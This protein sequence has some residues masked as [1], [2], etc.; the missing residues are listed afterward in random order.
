MLQVSVIAQELIPRIDEDIHLN[1]VTELAVSLDK[2]YFAL[3]DADGVVTFRDVETGKVLAQ[4]DYDEQIEDIAFSQNEGCLIVVSTYYGDTIDY[5]YVEYSDFIHEDSLALH[6]FEDLEVYG[7]DFSEQDD[8]VLITP[9]EGKPKLVN[10]RTGD[11]LSIPVP[12]DYSSCGFNAKGNCII[13]N[14][15]EHNDDHEVYEYDIASKQ[16]K[17]IRTLENIQTEE[18]L[19]NKLSY[20]KDGQLILVDISIDASVS[21]PEQEYLRDSGLN[22]FDFAFSPDGKYVAVV[23]GNGTRSTGSQ[24]GY[25]VNQIIFGSGFVDLY[26]VKT[27]KKKWGTTNKEKQPNL[28]IKDVDWTSNETFIVGDSEGNVFSMSI[29]KEFYYR[30]FPLPRKVV[31]YADV[32]RDFSSIVYSQKG[33]AT[34]QFDIRDDGRR[35]ALS[36]V[37]STK[38]SFSKNG[39]FATTPPTIN[40]AAPINDYVNGLNKIYNLPFGIYSDVEGMALS[41][42]GNAFAISTSEKY[43]P[44]SAFVKLPSTNVE[45]TSEGE[46]KM[47]EFENYFLKPL[48][49]SEASNYAT[50][51][52]NDDSDLSY[53]SEPSTVVFNFEKGVK[54]TLLKG[55]EGKLSFSKDGSLL[56]IVSEDLVDRVK[57]YDLN[58]EEWYSMPGEQYALKYNHFCQDHPYALS[59]NQ[60]GESTVWHTGTKEIIYKGRLEPTDF[61]PNSPIA[62]TM[63]NL[64]LQLDLFAVNVSFEPDASK[65]YIQLQDFLYV[66]DTKTG[67]LSDYDLHEGLYNFSLS[68]NAK[69]HYSEEID[70]ENE[71][72]WSYIWDH[73]GNMVIYEKPFVECYD[74][75]EG[76]SLTGEIYFHESKP[77]AF[78]HNAHSTFELIDLVEEE[79]I[80][81]LKFFENGEWV[82]FAPNGLFDGS[83]YG[84][85]AIYYTYGTE[86]ILFN[87]IK[88]KYWQPDLL[89]LLINN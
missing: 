49:R 35:A 17:L 21:I 74:P 7:I 31:T 70:S 79:L 82:V 52:E 88:N 75:E 43:E 41:E 58:N 53:Y 89:N 23:G 59:M 2:K 51:L 66:L 22:I 81:T 68:P 44:A 80:A 56:S 16:L 57:I 36:N 30:A 46:I 63:S 78:V 60:Y 72:T 29:A 3:A 83:K 6:T 32:S 62:Q 77:L 25:V 24:T 19:N 38:V 15:T 13:Y 67:Q 48:N 40:T 4:E 11:T 84:R 10:Y 8:Y 14:G 85:N 69:Y 1:D 37:P 26:E 87:Q 39:L 73:E 20:T 9:Q 28:D 76:K 18:D 27:G 86:V 71:R 65:M 34:Y 55:A 42:G 50:M 61:E 64:F 5:T 47:I 33:G 45:K 54:P 12:G